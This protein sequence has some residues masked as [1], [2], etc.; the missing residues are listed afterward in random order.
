MKSWLPGFGKE[1][2]RTS[3]RK[4]ARKQAS[5]RGGRDERD[6]IAREKKKKGRKGERNREQRARART[7]AEDNA[8]RTCDNNE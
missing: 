8:A 3:E 4:M 2:K 5:E 7:R 1:R 6:R